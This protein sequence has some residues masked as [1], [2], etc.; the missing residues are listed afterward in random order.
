MILV[1]IDMW[2]CKRNVDV[3]EIAFNFMKKFGEDVGVLMRSKTCVDKLVRK[4][5]ES[6]HI[7]QDE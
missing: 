4:V 6:D 5:S 2:V 7:R 1:W 3:D